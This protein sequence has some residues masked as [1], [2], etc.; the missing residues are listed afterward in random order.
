MRQAMI[1]P[2]DVLACKGYRW[3]VLVICRQ[4]FLDAVEALTDL[5]EGVTHFMGDT[6]CQ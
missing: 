5:A 6:S 1:Y 3:C 4:K 2:V